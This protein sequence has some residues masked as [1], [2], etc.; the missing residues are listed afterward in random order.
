[1]GSIYLAEWGEEARDV[2]ERVLRQLKADDPLAPVTVVM[3]NFYSGLA[4]RR[5]AAGLELTT[6]DS[7]GIANVSFTTLSRL[8]A[9][10]G[11][12]AL[13]EEGQRQ[14]T[15]ERAAEAIKAALAR[16]IPA[17][18]PLSAL[19]SNPSTE[20]AFRKVIGELEQ[21]PEEILETLKDSGK[22][23]AAWSVAVLLEYRKLTAGYY[24]S[25]D[26]AAASASAIRDN[27]GR[28]DEIGN[29]V[30]YCP[31][32]I[33]AHE[34]KLIAALAPRLDAIL[35]FTGEGPPDAP[36]VNL[37]DALCELGL[38]IDES[39]L[40]EKTSGNATQIL[41]APD[42]EEEVRM[43]VRE[44]VRGA[45][46]GEHLYRKAIVYAIDDPYAQLITDLLNEAGIPFSGA[47]AETLAQ[48]AA[49]RVLTGALRLV[50]HDYDRGD[51]I[52][53]INS[54][55][56][57]DAKTDRRTR[58]RHWD[59]VSR[60]A[61]V[62]R[63]AQEWSYRLD[64]LIARRADEV[65]AEE[66]DSRRRAKEIEIENAQDLKAFVADFAKASALFTSGSTATWTDF[67]AAT[68][69]LLD[70]YTGGEEARSK[71]QGGDEGVHV[72]AYEQIRDSVGS[73][74]SLVD[75]RERIS[76]E[77]FIQAVNELLDLP[78]PH[79]RRFGD[80]V[81][82]GRIGDAVA[83]DFES[84][85]V[86]GGR[87]GTM[88]ARR[89]DNPLI[90]D[91][92]RTDARSQA[93]PWPMILVTRGEQ[94]AQARTE[95]IAAMR[96]ASRDRVLCHPAG[97]LR[98][99]KPVAPARWVLEEAQA[100]AREN[101]ETRRISAEDLTGLVPAG[102]WHIRS[103][104]LAAELD[105]GSFTPTSA[106]EFELHLLMSTA[107]RGPLALTASVVKCDPDLWRGMA[108]QATR[109]DGEA[110]EFSGLV[111]PNS[112]FAPSPEYPISPTALEA[113]AKCPYKYML[114][115]VLR[116]TAVEKPEAIE[117]ISPLD[118]GSMIHSILEQ[119]HNEFRGRGAGKPWTAKERK[120]LHSIANAEFK[121]WE[122][123][124]VT[125]RSI[126]WE[127]KKS[128][129]H[130]LLDRF[131]D[132]DTRLRT[133]FGT[134]TVDSERS[135]GFADAGSLQPLKISAGGVEITVRGRIDR[136]DESDDGEIAIVIDY[137]TG[138]V[139]KEASALH[140]IGLSNDGE[141]PGLKDLAVSQGGERFGAARKAA[142]GDPVGSGKLLQLPIYALGSGT[143]AENVL[144]FY[145]YF[146]SPTNNSTCYGYAL[147]PE[148]LSR[149]NDVIETIMAGITGGTFPMNPG[150]TK[151]S[152]S[153]SH[154]TYCEFD[155]I[156][157]ND[158]CD[159]A[160]LK[161]SAPEF[162]QYWSLMGVI[163]E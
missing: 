109:R 159:I 152:S 114:E 120:K 87:E 50:Q 20:Q 47:V 90:S 67:A 62:I 65:K 68:A 115:K 128:R 91:A 38:N 33:K 158:R 163:D 44:I 58:G 42:P 132:A 45:E 34:W 156:C 7:R 150:L 111:G 142:F 117:D 103:V 134:S 61:G 63:G 31:V 4:L 23:L 76:S 147:S 1:M 12:P 30:L 86:L 13:I 21:V 151:T 92:E 131:V 80:G 108:A 84:I 161:S 60:N 24:G 127:I 70:R 2:L 9:D 17:D 130:R 124:G 149:L 41:T 43:V 135:F 25:A 10:L 35:A 66:I 18:E 78:A 37:R 69:D 27:P 98:T 93:P 3:P 83:A 52:A 155:A 28:L 100:L 75:L 6:G 129:T 59:Y 157:P 22:P 94:E 74:A 102:S 26:V 95:F 88:P 112:Q 11:A 123:M 19:V 105:S 55:P 113:W 137:K 145:W 99:G 96:S 81:F 107:G 64:A 97:D 72:R 51:L 106:D 122:A 49:G 116:L 39:T 104:S 54:G 119:F 153:I 73:L 77:V 14:I 53:W 125:G 82:I 141:L 140:R 79:E 121:K 46:R 29:L 143:S 8:A 85:Y 160:E 146:D 138:K 162:A 139:S 40:P 126:L 48:S 89:R 15:P 144:V 56:V 110:S 101:G 118:R 5:V 148:T 36:A 71:W 154:C 136:I 57:A 133:H 32:R 16:A